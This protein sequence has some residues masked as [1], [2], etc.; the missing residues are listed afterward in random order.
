MRTSTEHYRH[1]LNGNKY[2]CY[3]TPNNE[4]QFS[5]DCIFRISFAC[6]TS[7]IALIYLFTFE[8]WNQYEK[9]S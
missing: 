4:K 1:I 2:A 9:T 6:P 7:I 5:S 3:E 8:N